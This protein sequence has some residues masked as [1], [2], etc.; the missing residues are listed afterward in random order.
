MKKLFLSLVATIVATV[1]FAQNTLVATLSH[2]GDISAYYGV[3]AL[4]SAVTAAEA[5]DVITLSSGK[6]NAATIDKPITLRGVGMNNIS[7]S[8]NTREATIIQNGFSINFTDASSGRLIME[9]LYIQNDVTYSGTIQNAQI[10]KC[11]FNSFNASTASNT[12][13]IMLNTTFIHCRISK[14]FT[15]K[16]NSNAYFINCIVKDY[17]NEYDSSNLGFENCFLKFTKCT[18]STY[19]SGYP[20]YYSTTTW[21]SELDKVRNVYYKNCVIYERMPKVNSSNNEYVNYDAIDAS[22]TVNN[23][24]GL[25]Y[26]GIFEKFK[27]DITNTYVSNISSVFKYYNDTSGYDIKDSDNFELTDE[28]AQ[29]YLGDNGTQVGIYGGNM[30][31][32]ETPTFPKITKCKVASKST[33]DGKLSVDIEVKASSY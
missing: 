17:Y 29:T 6:Y 16:G 23:C 8:I 4:K 11:R 5:G 25:G 18:L 19:N 15:I 32:E 1:S 27:T 10:L 7:D 33:V 31:Y 12:T 28:A 30:P 14:E 2:Q 24:I 9:G 22:C 3:D 21:S 20:N 13:A 26:S